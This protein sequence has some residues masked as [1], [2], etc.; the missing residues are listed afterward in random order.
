MLEF[1][2]FQTVL[3]NDE[4]TLSDVIAGKAN[5]PFFKKVVQIVTARRYQRNLY[6]VHVQN[7]W[8]D[9]G[10]GR[11]PCWW[12]KAVFITSKLL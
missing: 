10:S 2:E 8:V 12:N 11:S 3:R 5:S 7:L 9:S 4:V 1:T 6:Q